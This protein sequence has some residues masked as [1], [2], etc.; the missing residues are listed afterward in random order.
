MGLFV[1]LW[2][3]SEIQNCFL[4]TPWIGFIVA[5]NHVRGLGHQVVM[6]S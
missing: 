1:K 5:M 2:G 3:L 4:K 6:T